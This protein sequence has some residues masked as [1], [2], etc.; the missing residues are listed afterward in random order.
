MGNPDVLDYFNGK[1]NTILPRE[2]A[3]ALRKHAGIKEDLQNT[4]D[5]L[6]ER[7]H[8]LQTAEVRLKELESQSSTVEEKLRSVLKLY[9]ETQKQLKKSQSHAKKLIQQ[10]NITGV[11]LNQ[12]SAALNSIKKE[13]ED[14]EK[15]KQ[16]AE[17]DLKDINK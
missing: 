6:I 4:E 5:N 9:A 15:R 11:E 8:D 16:D 3:E 14:L 2:I 7:K 17:A 1:G 12:A 10:M 13:A